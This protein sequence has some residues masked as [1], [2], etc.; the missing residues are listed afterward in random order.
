[1]AKGEAHAHIPRLGAG[2]GEDEVAEA[3]EA[4]NGFSPAAQSLS[5]SNHFGKAPGDQGGV[6]AAA[7]APAFD[8][9]TRYGQDVLHRAADLSPD[10]VGG[11]IGPE[12]RGGDG[13]RQLG[14]Q[15]FIGAGQGDGSGQAQGYFAGK[16]RPRQDCGPGGG[17]GFRQDLR[18]Q[19][20]GALLHPL[21][22][23]QDRG[24]G[25]QMGGEGGEA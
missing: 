17:Q 20:E 12:G 14:T 16:T 23:K 25:P 21:G 4:G 13:R 10:H 24:S 11:H 2:T 8:N 22:A 6:G 15:V 5:Q 1:M 7:Q 3:A 18:H 19:L 9:P